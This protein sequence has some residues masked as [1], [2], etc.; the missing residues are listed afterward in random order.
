MSL[1]RLG[2][3]RLEALLAK[4]RLAS[5]TYSEVGASRDTA[6]PRDFHH[7]RMSERVGDAASFDLA[8]EGLRTWVAHEG[9]GLR[10]YPHEPLTPG[11]TVLLVTT[12][13]PM[14]IVAPCRIVAVFKEPYSFGFSY[15]TLPDHPERGEESFALNLRNGATYFTITA[16]SKPVDPLARLAGPIG[17]AVQRSVTRR[18]VKALRRY[19]VT[20]SAKETPPPE[21]TAS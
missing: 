8:V 3:T 7:V 20:E 5:P 6:L 2:P 16:F 11:A 12:V 1:R 14:Q 17:R 19:V 9:A 13:G 18:Y 10:V 21:E 4:A 15:G